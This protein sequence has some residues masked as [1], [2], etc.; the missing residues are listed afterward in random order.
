MIALT[1]KIINAILDIKE[2]GF[3]TKRY[4]KGFNYYLMV[5]YLRD[6][7]IIVEDGVDDRNQ[8]RWVLSEIGNQVAE[9]LEKIKELTKNGNEDNK[10]Y[11]CESV[12]A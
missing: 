1:R 10:G 8:K 5:W 11:K 4:F 2:R 12:D 7:K 6:N 3:I 9:C